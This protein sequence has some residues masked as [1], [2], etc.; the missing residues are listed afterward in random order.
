MLL[1]QDSEYLGQGDKMHKKM[2]IG[3]V[4]GRG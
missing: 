3:D 2:K 1:L 4:I